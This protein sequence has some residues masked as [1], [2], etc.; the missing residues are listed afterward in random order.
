MGKDK[1]KEENP[2]IIILSDFLAWK[3]LSI[4]SFLDMHL[5]LMA[6][7]WPICPHFLIYLFA[8]VVNFVLLYKAI[9]GMIA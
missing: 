6:C 4:C 9:G 8:G 2:I 7:G 1:V 3:N 5:T